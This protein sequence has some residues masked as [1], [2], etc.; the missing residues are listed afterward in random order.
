MVTLRKFAIRISVFTRLQRHDP[1]KLKHEHR[2]KHKQIGVTFEVFFFW[3]VMRTVTGRSPPM[4]S[5]IV[6][7]QATQTRQH[8]SHWVCAAVARVQNRD[9]EF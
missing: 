6:A 5:M 4:S 2:R 3:P 7:R 9:V 8:F 1:Y